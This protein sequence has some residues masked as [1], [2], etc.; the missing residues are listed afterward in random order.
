MSI[1]RYMKRL[2]RIKL[3]MNMLKH[4]HLAMQ[5]ILALLML[6]LLPNQEL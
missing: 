1:K 2:N 5:G 3:Y 4:R 6:M